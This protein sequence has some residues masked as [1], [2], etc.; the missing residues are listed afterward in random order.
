MKHNFFIFIT[1]LFLTLSGSTS[2]QCTINSSNGYQVNVTIIPKNIVVSSTDCPWGY[3]YNVQLD[4]TVTFTGSNIPSG[5]YTL[6]TTITCNNQANS[7]YGLPLSGGSGT[8]TTTTNPFIGNDGAAYQYTTHPDCQHATV[9]NL[10]CNAISVYIHGPGIPAQTVSCN[11]PIGSLPVELIDYT[12][13][14]EG[15]KVQLKWSTASESR[16]DYFTVYR[17]RDLEEW[18]IV[19]KVD[20]AGTTTQYSAYEIND[21]HPY[22]GIV[23]YKLTQ[24]DMD[25]TTL[26]KGIATVDNVTANNAFSRIYPNPSATGEMHVSAIVAD[27]AQVTILLRDEL[28][29]VISESAAVPERNGGANA[30]V[31]QLLNTNG[32]TGFFLVELYQDGHLLGRHK[33]QVTGSR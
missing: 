22:E 17:S 6:Q 33:A 16:N 25:G 21:A 18:E 20:G 8:G 11:Y 13:K 26:A 24:T 15:G 1:I 5:L 30:T 32:A 10:N 28:G 29:R 2:A 23:Y 12:A 9:Q 19:A 14:L 3:N 31:N 4:Y 7:F 27:D